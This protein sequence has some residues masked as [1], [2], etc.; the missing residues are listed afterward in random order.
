ML[1]SVGAPWIKVHAAPR[2]RQCKRH[3]NILDNLQGADDAS[4]QSKYYLK[5]FSKP[6]I[7]YQYNCVS[8]LLPHN[9]YPSVLDLLFDH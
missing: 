2:H 7:T 4:F 6:S 5:Q 8:F 9:Q 1:S 3:K